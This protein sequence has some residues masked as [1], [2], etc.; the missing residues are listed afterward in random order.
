[1]QRARPK[2]G[3]SQHVL[4]PV[5]KCQFSSGDDTERSRS[6]TMSSDQL[7]VC[8]AVL[9]LLR[10]AWLSGQHVPRVY[11]GGAEL[12]IPEVTDLKDITLP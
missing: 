1:M 6:F 8:R 3:D 5:E 11:V 4:L 12:N 2:R 9:L 7:C 10:R